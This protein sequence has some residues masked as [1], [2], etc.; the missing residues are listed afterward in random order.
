MVGSLLSSFLFLFV[1]LHAPEVVAAYACWGL[2]KGSSGSRPDKGRVTKCADVARATRDNSV[3][4]FSCVCAH[5][6]AAER[7][8]KLLTFVNSNALIA[9]AAN[10]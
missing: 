1:L 3:C 7:E 6:G 5:S 10:E 8:R 4:S 2:I 9:E